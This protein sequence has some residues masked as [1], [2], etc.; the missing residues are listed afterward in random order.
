MRFPGIYSSNPCDPL[1]KTRISTADGITPIYYVEQ[2]CCGEYGFV[3]SEGEW[4]YIAKNYHDYPI[5]V[6]AANWDD[7]AYASD[8]HKELPIAPGGGLMPANHIITSCYIPSGLSLF[9]PDFNQYIGGWDVS[10]WNFAQQLFDGASSFNQYLNSWETGNFLK[11]GR[12]F[13]NASSF[14]QNL[15]NWDVS[16]VTDMPYIF[17]GAPN[18]NQDLSGWCVSNVTDHTDFDVG[19]TSWQ[20]NFKPNFSYPPC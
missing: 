20:A 8:P 12:A 1:V 13:L 7:S 18:F 17:E 15:S 14:N 11:M 3:K 16:N 5:S 10:N 2:E 9:G 19:A 6:V 4:F